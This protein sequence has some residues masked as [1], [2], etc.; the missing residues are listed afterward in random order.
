MKVVFVHDHKFRR[1]NGKI[2]SP[3][4]LPN[5][6]LTRYVN[7]F[8]NLVVIGRIID[9]EKV[10]ASYSYISNPNITVVTNSEM[11]EQI[12]TASA[13]IARLPSINGYK[14]VF[15]AEK[16]KKPL[17]AEVVGCTFDAYW[18]YGIKGKLLALPAY[19][20]MRYCVRKAPYA[21]YVTSE[22]L[23][24][25]YP[26]KGKTASISNV[27]IKATTQEV[28]EQR[29]RKINSDSD[30]V[31]LGTAGAVDVEYKGQEFVIKAISE[32][33]KKTG[34]NVRYELAGSGSPE[35]LKRIAEECKVTD[36]TEFKGIIKHDDM[37]DWLDS[38]DIYIQPS[39]T[40]GLPRAVVE[41]MSRGLPCIATDCG[42][43]SE[44]IEK[45][46]LYN[47]NNKS[48]IPDL[49]CERIEL[50]E[51]DLG[52]VAQ[53]NFDLANSEYSIEIL[54][55]RREDFFKDFIKEYN[56]L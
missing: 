46:Y 7:C 43:N 2:Y 41:A 8:E 45:Q 34:K 16:Y 31:V 9:E 24:K 50:I 30:T 52:S 32:I 1:I 33:I 54:N 47:K 51:K 22:F 29:L 27:T 35:R 53:R 11:E 12:K 18:N 25:K 39:L 3:G 36:N 44:L 28:V 42:G 23:Q 15:L 13:V 48:I 19:L 40:E 4:G 6:V 20:L 5:D 38:V 26:N 17:L 21:V 37:N 10:N 49:I 14:A 55:K 56:L